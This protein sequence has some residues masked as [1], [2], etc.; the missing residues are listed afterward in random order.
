MATPPT[1]WIVN[2]NMGIPTYPSLRRVDDGI[3]L[4]VIP[5]IPN[6]PPTLML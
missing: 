5:I 4:H 2:L 3:Y 6:A 1:Y